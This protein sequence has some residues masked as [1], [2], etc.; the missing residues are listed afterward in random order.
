MIVERV[1]TKDYRFNEAYQD[2]VEA[3]EV[4]DQVAEQ[5]KSA[6]KAAEE[7]YLKKLEEAKGEVNKMVAEIGWPLPS[8]AN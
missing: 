6:A 3:R 4:A 5:N 7:E 8:G 2:A 1:S